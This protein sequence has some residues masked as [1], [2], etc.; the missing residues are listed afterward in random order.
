MKSQVLTSSYLKNFLFFLNPQWLQG[1][2]LKASEGKK[3]NVLDILALDF[4]TVW[5]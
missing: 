3:A 4:E 1:V 2:Y 5:F